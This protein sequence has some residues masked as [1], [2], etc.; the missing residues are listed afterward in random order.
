MAQSKK[1]SVREAI[2]SSLVGYVIAIGAQMILFPLFGIHGTPI[3]AHMG[4]SACFIGISMF[5]NYLVRRW[6]NRREK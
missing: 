4:I 5:K 6:F 1:Q 2:I 3:S